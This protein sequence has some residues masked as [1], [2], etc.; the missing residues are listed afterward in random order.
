MH[1]A[2]PSDSRNDPIQP[3]YDKTTGQLQLLV[4][5]RDVNHDGKVDRWD[6]YG[7]DRRFRKFGFSLQNDGQEDAW[8]YRGPDG[9]TARIESSPRRNGKIQR[10]EHFEHDVLVRAEDD[11]DDDGTIDKWESY[12]GP[13][14]AMVAFDTA[15]RG[16]ADRRLVYGAD[17]GVRVE[18]DPLGDGHFVEADPRSKP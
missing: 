13:R 7:P 8:G 11:T 5:K 14:L 2:R 3:I 1:C 10:I 17:G 9:T 12:D 4:V 6:Y 16:R 18:V 15:H